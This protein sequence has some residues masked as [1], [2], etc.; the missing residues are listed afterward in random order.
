MKLQPIPHAL[1]RSL[2]GSLLVTI[3]VSTLAGTAALAQEW[4]NR[5]IKLIVPYT[6]GTGQDTIARTL[7][8]KLTEKLGQAIVIENRPGAAGNIGTEMA[9]KSP[10]DGYTLLLTASPIV[11]NTLLYK[12]LSWDP[13]RDF[14]PIANVCDGYLALVINNHVPASN[15]KEFIALLKA[16]PGKMSYSSPGIGTPQ[17]FSGEMLK[18]STN[19]FMLHVPYRGSAGAI[20]GLI[21]GDV[22]AMFMPVHSALPQAAQGRLKVLAV[23]NPQRVSVAPSVP[24]MEQAGGPQ[25]DAA[26]WYAFYAPAKTPPTIVNRL[27]AA[28]GE[29]MKQPDVVSSLEK[30]G[31]S[32]NFLPGPQLTAL[33]RRDQ[34]RWG[35]VVK[36]QGLKGE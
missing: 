33:M 25:M 30:Q 2:I 34:E 26:V 14:V 20:T 23:A 35:K 31:L 12:D 13:Y 16:R 17:H 8:P 1:R 3:V 10:P 15:V 18:F 36:E 28:F 6:P 7:A 9:A 24:T 5:P 19:T 27:T 29:I 4:P 22:E 32:I 21:G 11:L